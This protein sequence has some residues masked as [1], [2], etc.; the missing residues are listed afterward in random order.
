[1]K[2][3]RGTATVAARG[4]TNQNGLL[5]KD[6]RKQVTALEDDLRARCESVDEYREKLRAEYAGAR[7]AERT[8]ATYGSWLEE[9]ITQ[10]AV[11]WVLACVFVRFCED[12]RLIADPWI[13]GP[14]ERLRDAEEHHEAFFRKHPEKNDRDWLVS[15]FEHLAGTNSTVAGLFDRNHNP[16]WELAPSYKGAEILLK[17]WRT[18]NA[19]GEIVHGFEDP[20]LDTRFLG[21]LYQDLSDHAQ[22]TYAL[23]QT[24][25][26]V[27]EFILDL[28]FKPALEEFGLTPIVE[29]HEAD[30]T[31]RTLPPGLRTID[32][33]CGSGHFLLGLFDRLLSEWR[34]VAQ[35]ENDWT[36]IR[37]ALDS[38]HGCD[39]NP[40]AAAIARFRL[41]MAAL[42]AAG[43]RHLNLMPSFPIHVAVGDS[44]L[45]GRG[46]S[47][48]QGNFSGTEV[49]FYRHEDVYEFAERS[50]LLGRGS[51]HVT[52]GNPP[53]IKVKDSAESSAYRKAYDTCGGT[54]ALSVP[55][56][57]RIFE[58]AIRANGSNRSAGY[59]AQI[60][61]NSFMKREFGKKLV[62]W[63]H[64]KVDLTHIIDT[65]GAYIP[66]HGT[67]TIILAGRNRIA[68]QGEGIKA[69]LG[70]KGEP[71]QPEDPTQGF[72][73]LAILDAY[74]KPRMDSPWV[75][76]SVTSRARW[77]IHPWSLGGGLENMM[78]ANLGGEKRKRLSSMVSLIGRTAHTGSDDS[79]L[80]RPGDWERKGV[81]ARHIVPLVEGANIRDWHLIP[82]VEALFPYT[83]DLTPDITDPA[84]ARHLWTHRQRLRD[85]RELGGTHEEV[86]LTW[87]EWSRWHPERFLAP[88]GISY[89]EVATHN[90]FVLDRG[91]KVFKQT[92]P[93]IKLPNG[94]S[95]DTH[96]GLL[97]I[98]NSS[99]VGFWL[100]Q[101]C[102][103]KGGSGIGRGIQDEFWESR[104]AFNSTR[105]KEIPIPKSLPVEVSRTLDDLSQRL[106]AN[107][108]SV[109]FA[110]ESVP[111]RHD[112]DV[113]RSVSESTHLQMISL[114][115]ELDWQVYRCYGL[116]SDSE[117]AR[118]ILPST[119][120]APEVRL[121]ERAFEIALARRQES[122]E[123]ETSWFQRHGSQPVTEI[124][125]RW[126]KWYREIVQA[127]LETI[128]AR[129]DIALFE[130]PE[131]KRRWTTDD[132]ANKE[133]LALKNWL[134][135]RCEDRDLWFQ[136][137]DGFEQPR[138]LTISQI[139]DRISTGKS[140]ADIKSTAKLYAFH[141]GRP[142]LSLEQ[143]LH[144]IL[145]DEHV[146]YL[147]SLRY[148]KSGIIKRVEWENI[149]ELQRKEDREGVVVSS[150]VPPLY[151]SSD[152]SA[153]SYWSNRGKLDV[154]GERFISYPGAS[155]DSDPTLLLGWAGWDHRDQAQALLNI[156]NDRVEQFSWGGVKLTPPL[157]GLAELM[158]WIKQW[159]S[160]QD[161][162]W[163]GNAAEEYQASL[164][165]LMSMH[166]LT[167]ADLTT[168]RPVPDAHV[169]KAAR[170]HR[171]N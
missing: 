28:A 138:T 77:S 79:Y 63:F 33:A 64:Q 45:H 41:L 44:L 109:L 121:G 165:S 61:A 156:I 160:A 119:S 70:I 106:V 126:P 142:N 37:R 74:N 31:V 7:D 115:E 89:A 86:G 8:A 102:H 131:Y 108:P 144:E 95:E 128:T 13:A 125:M 140:A 4:E 46:A 39:K 54:Y 105:V 55:F 124:P 134:L 48:R 150:A 104:H 73:W 90:N 118:L 99:T 5:L 36:L 21:D 120:P 78:L 157:A 163:G 168:W 112:L 67:P 136:M 116:L 155:P 1:M 34:K 11:A 166:Q 93:T 43:V 137:R 22:K 101:T 58:L 26:F 9:R 122:G 32:P 167:T 69:V 42:K 72:V 92:A 85:R 107:E 6:L 30:G 162:E 114:Q 129:Q 130:V 38:V 71:A 148:S 100:R 52:V 53:Y 161:D 145:E 151:G 65:S 75:S 96:L 164:E 23:L 135:N 127:R 16:L 60:T 97:G 18:V 117:C 76:A 40:F 133:R 139:A 146:P 147:S 171:G 80:A 15:A 132:W 17:F 158:P 51:Y 103:I 20:E 83:S 84:S 2:T 169:R 111:N 35:G 159:Y 3:T 66:G 19:N 29:V 170:N 10:A 56:A 59:T 110:S 12:N 50:D 47:G 141:L 153:P 24:P 68:F 154:P 14:G 27:E 98:L 81:D 57:Q 94:T 152:F 49:F 82:Q 91:G 143:V 123:I 25:V 62:S 149:W 88:L 87:Y 113:S